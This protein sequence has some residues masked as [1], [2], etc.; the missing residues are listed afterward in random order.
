MNISAPPGIGLT[1]KGDG[2]APV[3]ADVP[4]VPM[5]LSDDH[6]L[7]V[8]NLDY[9]YTPE[10]PAL[11][12]LTLDLHRRE[13]L[14]VIGPSGCGKST[15]LAAIAGLV[16]PD[17]GRVWWPEDSERQADAP[18]SGPRL[19]IMFQKETLLPWLNVEQN[20]AVGLRYVKSMDRQAKQDRVD[21]LLQ[22]GGLTDARHVYPRHLS[23]GMK[24]RAALLA[25]VAPLPQVLMLDEPFAALD[26]PTRVGI[27]KEV[28]DICHE[29]EVSVILVTHD[30]AE[31]ISLGDRVCILSARP[32]RVVSVH[33]VPFSGERDMFALRQ[34]DEFQDLYKVLWGELS[35]QIAKA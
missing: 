7:S 15:L 2:S 32:A 9:S 3:Q 25:S 8:E 33:D 5:S 22:M 18:R 27:H 12:D 1:G 31:A 4:D 28:L 34:T 20:V 35:N 10:A 23:G 17:S 6:V 24:R 19:T 14:S 29:M 13:V 11:R 21:R 26:E 30:L 16:A